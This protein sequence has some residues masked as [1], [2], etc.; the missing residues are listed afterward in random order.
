MI[1]KVLYALTM[2]LLLVFLG[3]SIDNSGDTDKNVIFLIFWLFVIL[4]G[5]FLT[6]NFFESQNIKH[7]NRESSKT[8]FNVLTGLATIL[9]LKINYNSLTS[10]DWEIDF[11]SLICIL[12]S[13]IAIV[14]FTRITISTE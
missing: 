13:I 8:Y 12:H 5:V 6:F 14:Y 7:D 3:L 1:K 9:V 2:I 4:Y 11:I 10:E